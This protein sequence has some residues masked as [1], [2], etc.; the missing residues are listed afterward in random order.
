MDNEP[1]P[2]NGHHEPDANGSTIH[3]APALEH[4]HHGSHSLVID[5][6]AGLTAGLLAPYIIFRIATIAL[7][8]FTG[9]S[10]DGM[11]ILGCWNSGINA[12]ATAAA[13]IG[14]I[15]G[16]NLLFAISIGYFRKTIADYVK[17]I[18]FGFFPA[19]V[20]T[21]ALAI[22]YAASMLHDCTA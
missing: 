14:G 5:F 3:E 6:I 22:I 11:R 2:G 4:A 7:I 17:G 21:G 1:Q 8:F 10:I 12:E 20:L 13:W 16:A 9:W 18:W 15:A 19:F